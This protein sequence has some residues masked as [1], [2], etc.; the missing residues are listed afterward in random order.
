MAHKRLKKVEDYETNPKFK[1]GYK[2]GFIMG[3]ALSVIMFILFNLGM[4]IGRL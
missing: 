3:I 1:E 4:V 2:K